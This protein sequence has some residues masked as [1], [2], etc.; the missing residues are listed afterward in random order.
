M[1]LDTVA[2]DWLGRGWLLLLAFSAAVLLA[3]TLRRPCR[4]WFGTERAFQLWLLPP[5]AMLASQLPHPASTPMSALPSVVYVIASAAVALPAHAVAATAL[6]WRADAMLLWLVGTI[7]TLL[8]AATAQRRYRRRLIDATPMLDVAI[9]WPVLRASRVDVGPALVGAWRVR[10]V[11]PADFGTR[12]DAAER[13]MILAHET[14]HARRGDGWWCL[15][16][17]MIAAVF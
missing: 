1:R 5:L 9:R 7:A 15:C 6:D 16:A 13:A 3:A 14:T 2:I 12:Y 10:I 17:Q 8:L 4:R 11:L